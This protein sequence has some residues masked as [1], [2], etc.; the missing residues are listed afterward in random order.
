MTSAVARS[1][2]KSST[3]DRVLLKDRAYRELKELIQT[4]VFPPH[5]S[6]SERQLV[7]RLG[8]SKTPIRSALENL[9]AQGLV[10]VSPQKGVLI[11]ELSARE[12]SEL[13]DVR[14]AVEPFIVSHL[15]R[16]SIGKKQV[17]LLKQNL[18]KQKAAAK[19][20]DAVAATQLDIEFHQ[21]LARILDNQEMSAWLEKCF[22]KLQRSVLRINSLV[23][24]RL[25]K[26]TQDHEEIVAAVA[27]G[28]ESLAAERMLSHLR[29]GRQFLLGI[30]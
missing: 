18:R 19:K 3:E 11:K 4:G 27:E 12:I 29:Y 21:L 25:H 17:D 2:S 16:R 9:E 24:G 7:K 1:R 13:F 26:S 30:E 20:E 10:S 14:N 28:D 23:A 15:A 8:M 22:D 6:V 5:S